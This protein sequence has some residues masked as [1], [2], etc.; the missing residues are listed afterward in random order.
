MVCVG[1]LYDSTRAA[2]AKKER[3]D[4]DLTSIALEIKVRVFLLNHGFTVGLVVFERISKIS[5]N[6]VLSL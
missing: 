6:P 2:A 1:I 4:E 5:H 3:K